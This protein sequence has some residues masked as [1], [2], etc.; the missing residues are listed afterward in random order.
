MGAK[1]DGT[2]ISSDNPIAVVLKDDN[3][4][5]ASQ[6]RSTIGDQIVPVDIT[7]DTYVVPAMG[8]P[9]LSYIV[10]TQD[11][12]PIYVNAPGAPPTLIAT[13]NAGEQLR[14]Q[15]PNNTIMVIS[16]KNGIAAP[17]GPPIYVLSYTGPG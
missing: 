1:L 5:T 13:L 11:N 8:N 12:T 10:A 7:G 6:G 3:L 16:S 17:P 15:S 4:N 9:N 14:Y 2:R